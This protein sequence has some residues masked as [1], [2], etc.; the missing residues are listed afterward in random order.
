MVEPKKSTKASKKTTAATEWKKQAQGVPLEVP[1]GNTCLARP[2][3]MQVFLQ[4]GMVPN[5]LM[6]IVN[7]AINEGKQFSLKELDLTP[8]KITDVM[9]LVDAVVCFVVTEPKVYPTPM[10]PT[11]DGEGD[12]AF[13]EPVPVEERDDS[14]LYVDEVD[15]EDK[16]FIFQFSVGGTRDVE[17]FRAEQ[18]AL[19]EPLPGQQDVPSPA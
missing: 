2:V 5:S 8:E 18:A 13:Q 11:G 15:L 7:A 9:T 19:V 4:Q 17:R 6:P 10:R 16:M 14:R 3:G 12:T 1:S